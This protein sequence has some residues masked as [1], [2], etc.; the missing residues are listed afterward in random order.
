M[1]QHPLRVIHR[2]AVAPLIQQP[3]CFV[4]FSGCCVTFQRRAKSAMWSSEAPRQ[5]SPP[6][7]DTVAGDTADWRKLMS[8]SAVSRL[9]EA[10]V[11]AGDGEPF[12]W[13]GPPPSS[14]GNATDDWDD[15]DD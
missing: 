11:R 14:S 2:R 7:N 8:P 9:A 6:T 4:S 12:K 1:L 3:H 15:G 13:E 5:E 10:D